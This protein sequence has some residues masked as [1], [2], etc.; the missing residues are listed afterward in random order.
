MIAFAAFMIG[1]AMLRPLG[2]EMAEAE[3]RADS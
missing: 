2:R 1:W 3:E